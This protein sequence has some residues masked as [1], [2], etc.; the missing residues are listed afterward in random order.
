MASAFMKWTKE[1]L[2]GS[3]LGR[4]H[5]RLLGYF[6]D[7]PGSLSFRGIF[8]RLELNN[9]CLDTVKISAELYAA[10]IPIKICYGHIGTMKLNVRRY[11]ARTG[12]GEL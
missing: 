9:V 4:V 3:L 12:W 2:F 6:V 10:G 7:L 5:E 11:G 1:R 8:D